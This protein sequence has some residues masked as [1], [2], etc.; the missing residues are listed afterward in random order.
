MKMIYLLLSASFLLVTVHSCEKEKTDPELELFCN[1][2]PAGWECEII[3]DHFDMNDIPRNAD[4]PVAIIKYR[5][6]GLEFTTIDSTKENPSLTLDLYPAKQKQELTELIQSQQMYS[7]CIPIYY[8]ETEDYYIITSPC[9]IN[10]GSFTEEADSCI[11]A[12]HQS[13]STI[14]TKMNSDISGD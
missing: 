9:F 6:P 7:W 10:K 2:K 1:V 14:L 11:S 13:L 3:R 8:G 4:N 12:L 5:N